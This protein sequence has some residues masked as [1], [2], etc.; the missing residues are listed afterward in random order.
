M[1]RLSLAVCL[2]FPL[3]LGIVV[4]TA[5]E[6]SGAALVGEVTIEPEGRPA[7]GIWVTITRVGEVMQGF[8]D[9]SANPKKS[10]LTAYTDSQ[11]RF[12][13]SNLPTGIYQIQVEVDSLPVWLAPDGSPKMTALVS[14]RDRTKVDLSVST[15]ASLSGQAQRED[16]RPVRGGRVARPPRS[17][18]ASTGST[19]SWTAGPRSIRCV[20]WPS[21]MSPA[22]GRARSSWSGSRCPPMAPPDSTA[23]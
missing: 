1:R 9:G 5:L 18:Q 6:A 10:K 4:P 13:L 16:G 8:P 17:R 7:N 21:W 12:Q 22:P 20:C 3:A 14:N 19:S 11:G 23:S 15:L 2:F